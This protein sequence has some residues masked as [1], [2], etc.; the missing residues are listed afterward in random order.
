MAAERR[1]FVHEGREIYQWDQTLEEVNV[2]VKPPPGVR[3]AMLDCTFSA[4]HLKLGLKGNKPFL[5]EDFT[6][7]IVVKDSVWLIEDGEIHFTLTKMRKA[8]TWPSVFKGHG[9]LDPLA[10]AEVQKKMLLER[11][12]EEHPG[13]DFSGADVNGAV[14]D[15]REFMGGVRRS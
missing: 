11:F 8:E 13:F 9:E 1:A 12:Q 5:D 4:G 14:P 15:P 7:A 10:K 2:Y 3:A 6:S